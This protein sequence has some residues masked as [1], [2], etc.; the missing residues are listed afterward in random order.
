MLPRILYFAYL[1]KD[2]P[3]NRFFVKPTLQSYR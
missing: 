1:N 3:Y 2:S